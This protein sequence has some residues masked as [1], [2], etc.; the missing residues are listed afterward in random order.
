MPTPRR[1]YPPEFR[2]QLIELVWAGRTPEEL[3]R[4]FEPPSQTRI[5]AY[6]SCRMRRAKHQLIRGLTTRSVHEMSKARRS[7]PPERTT[8][9]D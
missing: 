2:Q 6:P 4:E 9:E 5:R 3:S 1:T 7:P 8:H